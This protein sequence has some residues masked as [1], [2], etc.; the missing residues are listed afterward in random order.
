MPAISSPQSLTFYNNGELWLTSDYGPTC[1]LVITEREP[2]ALR[3]LAYV[4]DARLVW[5]VLDGGCPNPCLLGFLL[6]V[7]VRFLV[8]HQ[9][10]QTAAGLPYFFHYLFI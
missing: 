8:D 9:E 3:P 6:V 2:E 10:H 5:E 4:Y 1:F 7:L